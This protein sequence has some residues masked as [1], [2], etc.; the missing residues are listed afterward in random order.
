MQLIKITV[1]FN[2]NRNKNELIRNYFKLDL[3]KEMYLTS[4]YTS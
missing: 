2:I 4:Y 3:L 1:Q